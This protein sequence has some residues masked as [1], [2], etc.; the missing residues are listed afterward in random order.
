MMQLLTYAGVSPAYVTI[1]NGGGIA[2]V[3]IGATD[4]VTEGVW[5]WDGDNDGTL[6]YS[7]PGNDR[8]PVLQYIVNQS[9]SANITTT[10]TGYRGEDINMNRIIKYS[11]PFNDPSVIIQNL[12][13]LTGSASI[14]SVYNSVIPAGI[15]PF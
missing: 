8:G 11:S 13:G 6:K 7:G 3:W 15:A 12:A 14:T 9:G 10:V 5:Y 4:N 2:Y 1:N